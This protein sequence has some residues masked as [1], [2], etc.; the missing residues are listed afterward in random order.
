[1]ERK[2]LIKIARFFTQQDIDKSYDVYDFKRYLDQLQKQMGVK[3]D[4]KGNEGDINKQV[5]DYVKKEVL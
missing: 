5:L 4:G 1:M 3:Q 2:I